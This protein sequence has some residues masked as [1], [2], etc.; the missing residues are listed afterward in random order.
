MPGS[1]LAYE[2]RRLVWYYKAGTSNSL[3]KERAGEGPA[4]VVIWY[5]GRKFFLGNWAFNV[6]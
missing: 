3:M 1:C 2:V 4:V 5:V 6:V